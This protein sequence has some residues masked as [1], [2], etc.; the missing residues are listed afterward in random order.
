V[1]SGQRWGGEAG[2]EA[3]ERQAV[4]AEASAGGADEFVSGVAGGGED[5][6]L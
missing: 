1:G 3:V 6:E 5:E 2:G 4:G